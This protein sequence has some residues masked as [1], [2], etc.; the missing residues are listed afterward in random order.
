MEICWGLSFADGQTMAGEGNEGWIAHCLGLEM[1][2]FIF[3][4]ESFTS[5]LSLCWFSTVRPLVILAS[6][7]RMRPSL[8]ADTAWKTIPWRNDPSTRDET[9][10]LFDVLAD[11]TVLYSQLEQ[12]ETSSNRDADIRRL[13][14]GAAELLVQLDR[15]RTDVWDTQNPDVWAPTPPPPDA[16]PAPPLVPGGLPAWTTLLSYR[17][18]RHASIL[19]TSHATAIL[20]LLLVSPATHPQRATRLLDAAVAVCRSVDFLLRAAGRGAGSFRLLFPIRMAHEALVRCISGGSSE[21]THGG[22]P[23]V[24]EWLHDILEKIATGQIGHWGVAGN[25]VRERGGR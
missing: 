9:Q 22:L 21:G 5:P 19:A 12:L 7:A 16:P 24:V 11:C 10:H 20:L 18:P 17:S 14:A 23:P 6:L 1:M 4:P 15:W 2:L 25:L 13:H 3:G 8:M